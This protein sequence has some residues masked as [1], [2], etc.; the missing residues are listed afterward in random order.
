MQ[1]NEGSDSQHCSYILARHMQEALPSIAK[2]NVHHDA[3]ASEDLNDPLQKMQQCN[4][5]IASKHITSRRVDSV[6]VHIQTICMQMATAITAT[7]AHMHHK[8]GFASIARNYLPMQC[9]HGH[10]YYSFAWHASAECT[11]H[12]TLV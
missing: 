2:P 1:L 11:N 3:D 7:S 6:H 12:G 10:A 5:W 9:D 8:V 4:Q